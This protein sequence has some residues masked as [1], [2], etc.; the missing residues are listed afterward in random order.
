MPFCLEPQIELLE[1]RVAPAIVTSVRIDTIPTV[2]LNGSGY[3]AAAGDLNGDDHDDFIAFSPFF[4]TVKVFFGGAALFGGG[5]PDPQ[6]DGTDGFTV[7]IA[8]G[9]EIRSVA[10]VG[11]FNGDGTDDIGIRL[12]EQSVQEVV[13]VVYGRPTGFPAELDLNDLDG[14]NGFKITGSPEL[15]TFGADVNGAGDF[16]GDN[17]DD[18]VI[19]SDGRSGGSGAAYVI[20]GGAQQRPTVFD[21]ADLTEESGFKMIGELNGGFFG[22]NAANAGDVNGDGLSDLVL[23][24]RGIDAAYVVFG[25]TSGFDKVLNVATLDGSNGFK[26]SSPKGALFGWTVESAG[27]INADGLSDVI[28]T[29]PHKGARGVFSGTSYVVF[30]K[31]GMRPAELDVTRLNGRNGF[32]ITGTVEQSSYVSGAEGI[33]DFNGDGIEDLRIEVSSSFT[34]FNP[35]GAF[36]VLYGREGGVGKSVNLFR[37]RPDQGVKITGGAFDAVYSAARV[38][39]LNEDGYADL[40]DGSRLILGGPSRVPEITV[41]KSSVIYTEPDGDRVTVRI[42]NGLIAREYVELQQVPGGWTLQTLELRSSNSHPTRGVS[43]RVEPG[44]LGDGVAAVGH[45]AIGTHASVASL[46]INGMLSSFESASSA[47]LGS[48]RFGLAGEF[49][50]FTAV[51]EPH[52]IFGSRPNRVEIEGDAVNIPILFGNG[53]GH[54]EINGDLVASTLHTGGLIGH[55]NVNGNVEDSTLS[56]VAPEGAKASATTLF[57]IVSVSGDF[58]RSQLLAGFDQ[59]SALTNRGSLGKISIE[60]ALVE[61]QIIAGASSGR[62]EM[63]GTEDDLLVDD[64]SDLTPTIV[65]L[66]VGNGGNLSSVVAQ[67]IKVARFHDQ[68]FELQSGPGNDFTRRSTDDTGSVVLHEVSRKAVVQLKVDR[69]DGTNGFPLSATALR[70]VGDINGDG[71]GDFLAY[72]DDSLGIVFGREEGVPTR[73]DFDGSRG[74]SL[75]GSFGVREATTAGDVNGDGIDDVILAS[76]DLQHL[77]VFVLLG[78]ASPFSPQIDF[79]SLNTQDGF[80]ITGGTVSDDFGYAVSG[81]GDINGDGFDDIVIGAPFLA[82]DQP[83]ELNSDPGSAYVVFG[84]QTFNPVI[85]TSDLD[86][87]NGF[88]IVGQSPAD[89]AGFSVAGAGDVNGDGWSDVLIGASD[90]DAS[91]DTRNGAVYI[92]FGSDQPFPSSLSL[93]TP[94][95]GSVTKIA[96]DYGY[97]GFGGYILG[98]TVKG[99]GDFNGDALND[100]LIGTD[101]AFPHGAYIIF[102][103]PEFSA[104]ERIADLTGADG[105]QITNQS[106]DIGP[107][108]SGA[109]DVNGDGLADVIIQ[110]ANGLEAGSPGAFV[111]FGNRTPLASPDLDVSIINGSNGFVIQRPNNDFSFSITGFGDFNGDGFSDVGLSSDFQPFLDSDT[112]SYVIFGSP[113]V[114]IDEQTVTYTEADGDRVILKVSNGTITTGALEFEEVG[115]QK[116]YNVKTLDLSSN[117]KLNGAEVSVTVAPSADSASLPGR[118]GNVGIPNIGTVILPNTGGPAKVSIDGNVQQVSVP[119][120]AKLK[121]FKVRSLGV[122]TDIFPTIAPRF[123]G[124]GTIVKVTVEGDITSVDFDVPGAVDKLFV[125]GDITDSNLTFTNK[126]PALTVTGDVVN[127]TLSFTKGAGTT[128]FG[129]DFTRSKLLAGYDATGAAVNADAMFGAVTI[130]GRLRESSIVA[131]ASAGVDGIFGTD[132]DTLIG[133]GTARAVAKIASIVIGSGVEG[134]AAGGDGFGIVAEQIGSLR[135]GGLATALVRGA[136]N[137]LTP[138]LLGTTDDVRVRE[139]RAS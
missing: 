113:A 117:A 101:Q 12:R 87:T 92:V 42:Q 37:L 50:R 33:G 78:K 106:V 97:G 8:E 82:L 134:N 23:A 46:T 2:S 103:D 111:I 40:Y 131:G 110:G 86:G 55:L 73:E 25:R 45:V 85:Q 91:E 15:D 96:D 136:G 130:V 123:N 135:I 76:Y 59:T 79:N 120:A 105:F 129:G 118:S 38:G 70:G 74:F 24:D 119:A 51:H 11:D 27:D 17:F 34:N 13:Y 132:D 7:L 93:A 9:D 49:T 127:S 89:Y 71:L 1:S 98:L 139:V 108:V 22:S 67:Y 95:A 52:L 77:R 65:S 116:I 84:R 36:I 100:I 56:G 124:A 68:I 104:E 41:G 69:L 109:G 138:F 63:F 44:I 137:D 47:L 16:N 88:R 99:I 107:A 10:G 80:E 75:I 48:I 3:G 102:G 14:L 5:N 61:S 35:S 62:D 122:D 29:D 115:G 60:G 43:I 21:L 72:F 53:A 4:G 126:L 18:I 64:N 6:L 81:A 26:I 114:Q 125:G 19:G 30:G 121:E 28:I 112:R 58:T 39:D 83:S 128:K 31:A 20:F 133:G 90:F 94:V 57:Q 66:N 54:I 32:T